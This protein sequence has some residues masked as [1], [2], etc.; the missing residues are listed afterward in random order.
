MI[1]KKETGVFGVVVASWKKFKWAIVREKLLGPYFSGTGLLS[2]MIAIRNEFCFRNTD[3]SLDDCSE[4]SSQF[5]QRL[6]VNRN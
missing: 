6:F 3:T 4:L 2:L 5:W 1:F